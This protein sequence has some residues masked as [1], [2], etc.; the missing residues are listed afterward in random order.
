MLC[1]LDTNIRSKFYYLFLVIYANYI[2][3]KYEFAIT[4][5]IN[6]NA[7]SFASI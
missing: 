1:L 7:D 3:I 5:N 4:T 6:G 2:L